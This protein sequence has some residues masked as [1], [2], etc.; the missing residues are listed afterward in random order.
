MEGTITK[1]KEKGV[2]CWKVEVGFGHTVFFSIDKTKSFLID[3]AKANGADHIKFL[4]Q[5]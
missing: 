2:L 4:K 3:H 5:V 1:T